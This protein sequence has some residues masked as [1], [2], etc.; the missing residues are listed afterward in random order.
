MQK[1]IKLLVIMTIVLSVLNIN[2]I[3]FANTDK[4]KKSLK[5]ASSW[6][7]PEIK[8]SIEKGIVTDKLFMSNFKHNATREEFAELV[9]VLLDK[10]ISK[11]DVDTSVMNPFR[12]TTNPLIVKAYNNG[13]VNGTSSDTFS[14]KSPLTRE[15]LCTMLKRLTDKAGL[16]V[17]NA[18]FVRNYKDKSDISTWALDAVRLMNS[19]AIIK[20]SG[21]Y[22]NPK[23]NVTKEM[24]ILLGYRTAKVVENPSSVEDTVNSKVTEGDVKKALAEAIV[25]AEMKHGGELTA[26]K[27][28]SAINYF[29]NRI[30]SSLYKKE[31]YSYLLTQIQV[32]NIGNSLFYGKENQIDTIIFQP[33]TSS[34]VKTKVIGGKKY[35][36]LPCFKCGNSYN[37]KVESQ[38]DN[39]GYLVSETE[40]STTNTPRKYNVQFEEIDNYSND[41]L[42]NY[43]VKSV[44]QK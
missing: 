21:D 19:V 29:A 38:L 4:Y 5:T 9:A 41:K 28:W 8:E 14:P 34:S 18:N 25:S 35:Y 39:G 16:S 26:D 33:S 44:E 15:Q 7:I 6:A 20:G 10:T 40:F 2:T 31:N 42:F 43:Y 13:L 12:D 32:L 36:V 3:S 11:S 30:G 27:F 1:K 24:A 23:G 37:S 22:L 17:Q